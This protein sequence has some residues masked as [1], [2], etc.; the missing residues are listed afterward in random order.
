[1]FVARYRNPG[2]LAVEQVAIP[3]LGPDDVLVRVA[4]CGICGSDVHSFRTGLFIRPGQVMGHEFVGRVA[5]IGERV[6]GLS[7]GD[8]VTGFEAGVCETC[9]ACR[10]GRFALCPELFQRSTG[11]GKPG[12]LAEYVRIQGAALGRNLFAVPP[13][14]SDEAAALIEPFSVALAAV[15]QAEV[16]PGASVLV[17]GGGP[18]GL[19]CV[20]AA[21][22]AGAGLI[23]VCEPSARR[24]HAA[25]RL[26]AEVAFDPAAGDALEWVKTT[27]GVGRYHF[28][29]GGLVDCIIE[30]AGVPATVTLALEAVRSAGTVVFLALAEKPALLDVTKIVHKQPRILG[31]LGGSFRGAIKVLAKCSSEVEP[32]V[33][34]RFDLERVE[35]AFLTQ[36]DSDRSVKVLVGRGAAA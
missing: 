33:T 26:G 23:G 5:A 4:W 15:Q 16:G 9:E 17:L 25:L 6:D 7:V 35:E 1:M 21:R 30:A 20:V 19:L 34:H 31:S 28:H 8:R 36:A 24:R 10:C 3:E 32:L 14:I 2:R 13:S 29:D 12:A 27:F 11:Y 18:I 22:L